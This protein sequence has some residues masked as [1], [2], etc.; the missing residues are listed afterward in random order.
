MGTLF[1]WGTTIKP[2]TDSGSRNQQV[3]SAPNRRI[4]SREEAGVTAVPR[5]LIPKSFHGNTLPVG[6]DN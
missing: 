2:G 3:G 1:Q 5:A 6:Y 4:S